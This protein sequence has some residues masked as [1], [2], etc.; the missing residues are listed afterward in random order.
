MNGTV[1][2]LWKQNTKYLENNSKTPYFFLISYGSM[3]DKF[4]IWYVKS[5][6]WGKARLTGFSRPGF[7]LRHITRLPYVLKWQY[8]SMLQMFVLTSAC[9]QDAIKLI[10]SNM[11]VSDLTKWFIQE[12]VQEVAQTIHLPCTEGSRYGSSPLFVLLSS[13]QPRLLSL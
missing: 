7:Y 1:P 2:I 5:C 11:H 6:S 12:D 10:G 13:V 8:C 3:F 4:G 9:W